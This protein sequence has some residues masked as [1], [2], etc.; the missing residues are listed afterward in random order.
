MIIIS[1]SLAL[2]V[3]FWTL[4]LQKFFSNHFYLSDYTC[5]SLKILECAWPI[6]VPVTCQVF[7]LD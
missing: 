5:I 6:P 1:A 3:A 4:Y 2:H 7:D